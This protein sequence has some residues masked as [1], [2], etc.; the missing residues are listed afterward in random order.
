MDLDVIATNYLC[1]IYIRSIALSTMKC[2]KVSYFFIH[3]TCHN[4]LPYL[5]GFNIIFISTINIITKKLNTFILHTIYI[6]INLYI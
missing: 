5:K 2:M 3:A 4:S 6:Y 1:N